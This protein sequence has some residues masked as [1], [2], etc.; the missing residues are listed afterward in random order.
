MKLP[1]LLAS[2]LHLTANPADEYRW[3]LFPWLANECIAEKAQTLV[4]LGD[5]TDA[6]DY[7][8]AELVNRTVR[9]LA[10]LSKAVPRIVIL[11]GN[12]DYLK[13]GDMFFQFLDALPGVEVLSKPTEDLLDGE[14]TLFLPHTK[15][16]AK[17]WAGWDFSHFSYVFL[18][19]TIKGAVASNGQKMDGEPLPKFGPGR[20]YSGDIHV[21]QVLGGV[22][23]VGSPYHVHFGDRFK[24]RC[25]V[26]DKKHQAF[27]L[28]YPCL[29]RF[30]MDVTSVDELARE[31]ADAAPG[32]QIKVRMHLP[33][34]AK[35]EW[36]S[37]SKFVPGVCA[38]REVVLCGLELVVSKARKRVVTGDR[39]ASLFDPRAAVYEFVEADALGG[40]LLDIGLECI[41]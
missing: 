29:S 11:M 30:T 31:L 22:E 32:D 10:E 33:E 28:H 17:D 14:A 3:G 2:D 26:I 20:T 36:R 24:P 4:I 9:A 23:Y 12:H 27:D 21:P 38:E 39:P 8:P 35:H 19:Q 41:E 13:S 34:S 6:K 7:H 18:H 5:L 16:P 1:A 25:V 15:T 37:I 40:P